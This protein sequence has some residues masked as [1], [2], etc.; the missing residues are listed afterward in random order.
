MSKNKVILNIE[1]LIGR[2]EIVVSPAGEDI[3]L[4][5][6]R[7]KLKTRLTECCLEALDNFRQHPLQSPARSV[8]SRSRC[9]LCEHS[10]L[11]RYKHRRAGKPAGR[12]RA[13]HR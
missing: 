8:R 7:E 12:I 11:R 13:A 4:R 9:G 10:G 1:Q 3:D 5:S 2:V 6:L